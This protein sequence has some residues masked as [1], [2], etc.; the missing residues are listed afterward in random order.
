[1]SLTTGCTDELEL[2][3]LLN[4]HFRRHSMT[5]WALDHFL[6][7]YLSQSELSDDKDLSESEIIEESEDDC[8]LRVTDTKVTHTLDQAKTDLADDR[9]S[10]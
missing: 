10:N 2:A 3:R 4:R 7:D 8:N 6:N 5:M 1:M 9:C